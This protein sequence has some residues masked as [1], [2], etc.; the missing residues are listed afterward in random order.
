MPTRYRAGLR[1]PPMNEPPA[2]EA[3]TD[4]RIYALGQV[5]ERAAVMEIA[6]RMAFCAL[7]GGM[8][9]CVNVPIQTISASS[10]RM[11]AHSRGVRSFM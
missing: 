10:G 2:T 8:K 3:E 1:L 5:V 9:L 7:I 11:A 4:D 6:L